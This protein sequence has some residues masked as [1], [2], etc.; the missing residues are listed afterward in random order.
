MRKSFIPVC[1]PFLGEVE[2]EYLIDAFDSGW[3]SSGGLYNQ[4]LEEEFSAYCGV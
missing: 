4:K 3:I 2:R 1:E